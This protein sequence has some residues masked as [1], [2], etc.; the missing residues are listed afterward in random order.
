MSSRTTCELGLVGEGDVV[1][2]Y[3]GLL[4]ALAVPDLVASVTGVGQDRAD[5]HLGPGDA[6]AVAA[7]SWADEQ[8]MLSRVGR[9][10]GWGCG[11]ERHAGDYEQQRPKRC[12]NEPCGHSSS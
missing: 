3:E 10:G 7:R 1:D 2:V 12:Q 11:G 5:G 4:A 6:G 8:G 9:G